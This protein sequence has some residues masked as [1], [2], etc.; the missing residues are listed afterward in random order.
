MPHR[1]ILLDYASLISDA[2]SMQ[3]TIQ[4]GVDPSTIVPQAL[5]PGSWSGYKPGELGCWRAHANALRRVVDEG[6]ETALIM[7]GDND[8]DVR[9]KD[10]MEMISERFPGRTEEKPYGTGWDMLYL[11]H[12]LTGNDEKGSREPIATWRDETVKDRA[13]MDSWMTEDLDYWNVTEEKTRFLIPSW[14]RSF[15]CHISPFLLP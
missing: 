3:L 13:E 12:C 1:S 15:L 8:W 9:V 6:L 5:P 4:D 10:Q 14:S 2:T 7:E 11:G